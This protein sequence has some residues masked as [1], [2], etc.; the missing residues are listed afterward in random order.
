MYNGFDFGKTEIFFRS[1]L[2][3]A[4]AQAVPDLPVGQNQFDPEGD[5]CLPSSFRG[6]GKREPESVTTI[7]RRGFGRAI[8]V[9]LFSFAEVQSKA[10]RF[11][12]QR[13]A[14]SNDPVLGV[15][16]RCECCI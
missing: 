15:R 5:F 7:G 13:H 3:K 4:K 11:N 14:A 12:L 1:G 2:D 6:Q 8:G 10:W 9:C 16:R